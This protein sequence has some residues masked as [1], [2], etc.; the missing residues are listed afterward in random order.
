MLKMRKK[1]DIPFINLFSQYKNKIKFKTQA[2]QWCMQIL[3]IC[4]FC[5]FPFGK[6]H[7]FFIKRIDIYA[8]GQN[9]QKMTKTNHW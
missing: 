9:K 2:K 7:V 3:N 6:I 4:R 5:F 1:A 8:K